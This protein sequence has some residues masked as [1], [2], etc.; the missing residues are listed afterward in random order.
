MPPISSLSV[1]VITK[2]ESRFI[3]TCLRS[4][5]QIAA[6]I[7]IVDSGST[8][9]TLEI[10]RGFNARI[11]SIE[12]QNDY[13]YARNVAIS[14]CTG[15]WIFFLDADEYLENPEALYKRINRTKN[16]ITGGFL[17]ERTDIYRHKENGLVIKYPVGLV[18]LFRNHLSF[19]Y[20]GS[21]HEQINTS[22]TNAGYR[23]EILK[24]AVI[25]HQV[26]MSDDAFLEKK[27][28]RYLELIE[29]ELKKDH[30]NYWMHYQKAK[31]CW[32]L[33]RKEE[34]KNIF[35]EIADDHNCPLVLRCSGFC[36]KAVLLME[37]GKPEEALVEVE[38]S[39]RLN[40]GQSLGMMIRGNI[41][42][43][44]NEFRK[45]IRAFSKVKTR[46][47]K[48]KYNQ[49]IPGDLYVKPEEI[50]YKIACCYLAM[51]KTAAAKFLINR[52]LKI[53]GNH[54]PALLLLAKMY[55]SKKETMLAR[56]LVEKCL[57][58]NPGW[59]LA[60]DFKAVLNASV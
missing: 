4:V 60:E 37:A 12:W 23:I 53:N 11:F 15:D 58:L 54:V 6:E 33:E 16:K 9:N 27:Q 55:A 1:C 44:K 35:S 56:N 29:E 48:L 19:Q 10:A 20:A 52:A 43:Q 47:N 45:S 2:N 7:I 8:D 38:K 24:E 42:Y 5:Q 39:L 30:S 36:N 41:L 3:E 26:Y 51:G 18:R 22:I 17:M 32:F 28:L 40:P 25:I 49:V 57:T 50:K 14:K 59:K 31:T 21:V 46:I 13:A 34:A